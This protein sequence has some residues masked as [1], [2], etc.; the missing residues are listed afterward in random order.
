[1]AKPIKYTVINWP[2]AEE[3]SERPYATRISSKAG[4]R[5]S[6]PKAIKAISAAI[7]AVMGDG[8]DFGTEPVVVSGVYLIAPVASAGGGSGFFGPLTAAELAAQQALID[9]LLG[10]DTDTPSTPTDP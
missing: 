8:D 7:D 3:S 10:R 2:G 4:R 5:I 9:R 6:I 1:M